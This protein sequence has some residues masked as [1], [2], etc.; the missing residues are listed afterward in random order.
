[1]SLIAELQRRSV[2]KVAVAYLVVGWLVIQVA[3]TVAPQ[4]GLPEW[5]PRM[6]TLVV[7][8]GFPL[9]L[10][11]A[12]VFDVTPEG[13]KIEPAATGNKRMYTVAAVLAALAIGWFLRG[14]GS[15]TTDSLDGTRTAIAGA[16]ARSIAVLPFANMSGDPNH[17]YFSDGISEEI[18][19]VLA[20]TPELSVA[21]RTSSFAY[22]GKVQDIPQIA[23][24]LKVRMVLEGSVR[25]QGERVR[26][27]AQLIDAET[28]YHAW[29]QTYDR[30]LK[31]IFAIQDE[32]ARAIGAELKVRVGGAAGVSASGTTDIEAHDLYLRALSLWQLRREV[33]L[34]QAI[35]VL[36]QSVAKD[37]RYA[38]A[39][40]GLALAY[41]VLPDYS[42]KISYADAYVRAADAA[43]MAL[44][45]DPT[46]A[47]PYAVLATIAVNERRRRTAQA[48]FERAIALQ[49]SFATAHQWFGTSFVSA[50]DPAP[51]LAYSER[52]T[53]LDPRSR[54]V[55]NNHALVLMALARYDDARAVCERVL[56]FA[57]DYAFCHNQIGLIEM[58]RGEPEKARAF[59]VRTAEL[60]N[61]SALPLVGRVVDALQGHGDRRAVA[62]Q[63]AAFSARA[64]IDQ[65]SGT[66]FGTADTPPIL[67]LLGEPGLAL[68]Y[69]ERVAPE[70]SS[71]A[72]WG[73]AMPTL[74]PIR[75]QPRFVALAK[76]IK[77]DDRR[78]VETCSA[79]A[80]KAA[81]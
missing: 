39:Y 35:E 76:Q 25:K 73:M 15:G 30:D 74:D 78:A 42:D 45:L 21:A 14:P 60:V 72:E 63:L 31:D 57:P 4:M 9:A 11:L 58:M 56:E 26:I 47:V 49:P 68:D 29:S 79:N 46:M 69:L 16:A 12:W 44:A 19:N 24:D 32:I 52:S 18:L 6:V 40:G 48:L 43:S 2:F 22:K 66:I 81:P 41:A 20:R 70:T 27:T 64:W 53:A 62:R 55:G 8:L 51:G 80:A 65:G 54:V 71:G 61:P 10:M 38:Q 33:E 34:W 7:M 3:A 28:G 1:M 17:E 75:C 23:R 59:Y 77:F 13:L 5:T 50:G 37:P 36:E 67:V